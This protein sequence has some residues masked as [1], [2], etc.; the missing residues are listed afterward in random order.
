MSMAA[1]DGFRISVRRVALEEPVRKPF[2]MIIPARALNELA[3]I[4]S[5]GEN[6]LSMIVSHGTRTGR[7]PPGFGRVGLAVDRWQFPGL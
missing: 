2:N 7:V 4:A 5:D 6:T 1:T 3:R